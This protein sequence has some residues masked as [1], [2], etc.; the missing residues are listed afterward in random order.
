MIKF[1]QKDFAVR[2]RQSGLTYGEIVEKIPV[3]KS[4]LNYWFTGL[5]LQRS[6]K[7]IL[8]QKKQQNL[9]KIRLKAI[10]VL[11]KKREENRIKLSSM[12]KKE[13]L[14]FSFNVRTK[15]LALAAL[16]LGE[17]FKNR[18]QVAMGNSN[19]EILKIF[20]RLIGDVYQ[21]FPNSL[22]CSLYLRADQSTVKE[23][24]YWSKE[25]GVPKGSFYKS[26]IDKR[27]KGKKTYPYY[28]GVCS[29]S[30]NNATIDKR[31]EIV[32]NIL[33]KKILQGN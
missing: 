27:T 24:A 4:T 10:Q 17:G 22:R 15:E 18:S 33:I 12:V 11:R 8:L 2:L 19:P 29:V 5:R 20:I 3:S 14:D 9:A 16:Y 13:F 7:K 6:A 25:L 32:Q 31:L 26:Q 30:C 23:V 28:H 21:I 1:N